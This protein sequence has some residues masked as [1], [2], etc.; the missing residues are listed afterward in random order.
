[1]SR[2]LAV[3]IAVTATSCASVQPVST[4]TYQAPSTQTEHRI[5]AS[6]EIGQSKEAFV[7]EQM[8]RVQDY[9]AT[10]S[11]S[12][13]SSTRLTPTENF[14]V[15]VPPFSSISLTPEDSVTVVG[16]T[17][18]DGSTFRLVSLPGPSTQQLKFLIT[19]E[20]AFEGSALNN[21]GARMGWS[22]SPQPETVRLI[23]TP[24]AARVDATKG[25][26]NFELVYGGTSRESFQILYREYTRDDLVRPAFSQ[27]LVYDKGNPSIRFRNLQIEVH[28]TTNE[29]IRFTVVADGRG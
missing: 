21:A 17:E 1:M 8:L 13:S 29:R 26:T 4:E 9:Y 12:G 25:F 5:D 27:T 19:N 2:I 10:V 11:E 20:G 24:S 23:Q 15:R 16:T 22:Y 18:R 14:T 3:L 7:G 6:Y 28:E